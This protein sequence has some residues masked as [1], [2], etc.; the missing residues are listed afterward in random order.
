[1]QSPVMQTDMPT[2]VPHELPT[3]HLFVLGSPQVTL[4]RADGETT[5]VEFR[6]VKSQALLA[7]LAA[8]GQ[9]QSRLVLAG[10]L[11]SESPE[12]K[13][14]NSLRQVLNDL[15]HLVPDHLDITHQ[16]VTLK[17][18]SPLWLDVAQFAQKTG[19]LRPSCWNRAGSIRPTPLRRREFI[20]RG[21]PTTSLRASLPAWSPRRSLTHGAPRRRLSK[22]CTR[23]WMRRK[24]TPRA[25][26]HYALW[27][28]TNN[29]DHAA[30][31][32]D[33]YERLLPQTPVVLYQ[34]RL[35]ALRAELLPT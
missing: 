31:A 33:L 24:T 4:R 16:T 23:C 6:M 1:M 12:K 35:D 29:A 20:W 11:W 7:Y 21:R 8:S 28:T 10:L 19:S 5:I 3:L 25:H 32:R 30:R 22:H 27:Q 34:D 18:D 15:R 2:D 9:P 14:L 26:V 13:A 17:A